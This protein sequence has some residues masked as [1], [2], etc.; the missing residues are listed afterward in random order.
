MLYQLPLK[1]GVVIGTYGSVPYVHL[2]LESL[3][4]NCPGVKAVV[5][6]DCSPMQDELRDLCSEYG[7]DFQ[8]NNSRLGLKNN[9]TSEAFAAQAR[10]DF[11]AYY[12]GLV[13][14]KQLGLDLLVK[15]SRRFIPTYDWNTDIQ[16]LALKTQKHTF[17]NVHQPWGLKFRTDCLG[18]SVKFWNRPTILNAILDKIH[19]ATWFMAE[20]YM[21]KLCEQ[22]YAI[23][24]MIGN[25][26]GPKSSSVLDHFRCTA[27][28][29][30]MVSND[31][32]LPYR[33][34]NFEL[35]D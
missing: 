23:W 17:S 29:Y 21:Y 5:H 14:A 13:W 27:K 26:A 2:G 30:L 11:T 35:S 32:G 31:Y 19:S 16:D 4:R 34:G 24:E 8:V 1:V 22:E 7:A 9:G 6:D 28:D 20:D 33:L 10:G 25:A 15:F 12:G 3:K 18:M